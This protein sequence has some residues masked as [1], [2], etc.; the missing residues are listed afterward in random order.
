MKKTVIFNDFEKAFEDMN[1]KDSFSSKGLVALFD[2]LE[3][4][5]KDIGQEV[6]LDVIAICCDFTEYEN[7]KEYNNYYCT[8]YES[9]EDIEETMYIPVNGKSFIIRDY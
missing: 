7:I 9:M 1:R 8:E 3:Q 2:Y 6:E 5:E 4:L